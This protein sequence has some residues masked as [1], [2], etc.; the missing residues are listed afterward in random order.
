MQQE[1]DEI[2]A[3]ALCLI[4]VPEW[5]QGRLSLL[6][7]RKPECAN[8]S[9]PQFFLGFSH[10]STGERHVTYILCLNLPKVPRWL[11]WIFSFQDKESRKNEQSQPQGQVIGA[12]GAPIR[13]LLFSFFKQDCFSGL[14]AYTAKR[15]KRQAAKGLLGS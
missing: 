1:S 11:T 13:Q 7:Y 15:K 10:H 4:S 9:T 8:P 5:M 3:G 14:S 2:R 12:E 6:G